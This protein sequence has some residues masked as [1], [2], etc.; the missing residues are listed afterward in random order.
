MSK[1]NGYSHIRTIEQ[2]LDLLDKSQTRVAN[3]EEHV[4]QNKMRIELLTKRVEKSEP[5]AE[6]F[7]ILLGA[8]KDNALVKAAWDKFM[9][10]LRMTGYDNS[11][12]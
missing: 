8:I 11:P 4:R 5:K 10:T 1:P 6:H 9:M 12:K 7:D 3:L 2:A